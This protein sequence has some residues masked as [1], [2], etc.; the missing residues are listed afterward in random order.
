MFG[1]RRPDAPEKLAM[2][3]VEGT[4]PATIKLATVDKWNYTLL[5]SDYPIKVSSMQKWQQRFILYML[6]RE[7]D[8]ILRQS[9]EMRAVASNF[10]KNLNT[11]DDASISQKTEKKEGASEVKEGSKLAKKSTKSPQKETRD[12]IPT[13]LEDQPSFGANNDFV[14]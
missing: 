8:P 4:S 1:D 11:N 2:R 3:L 12:N 6:H 5:P 10:I 9:E 7:K 14:L 13:V